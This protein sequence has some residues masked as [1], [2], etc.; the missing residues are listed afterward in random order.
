MQKRLVGIVLCVLGV[1]ASVALLWRTLLAPASSAPLADAAPAASTPEAPKPQGV[2]GARA[3]EAERLSGDA[4]PNQK[5]GDDDEDDLPILVRVFDGVTEQPVPG[6]RLRYWDAMSWAARL[7]VPKDTPLA[8]SR[9]DEEWLLAMGRIAICDAAGEARLL[10][11]LWTDVVAEFEGAVGVGKVEDAGELRITIRPERGVTVRLLTVDRQPVE[12]VAVGLWALDAAGTPVCESSLRESSTDGAGMARFRHLQWPL[13][14]SPALREIAPCAVRPRLLGCAAVFQAFSPAV[15]PRD[16]LELLLPTCGRVVV[17]WPAA[18]DPSHSDVLIREIGACWDPFIVRP[19][20][21][22]ELVFDHVAIGT[23]FEVLFESSW[24][25]VDGPKGAGDV[26]VVQLAEATKVALTGILQDVE[27]RVL[28]ERDCDLHSLGS[29]SFRAGRVRTDAAGRFE[30]A[31]YPWCL[32]RSFHCVIHVRAQDGEPFLAVPPVQGVLTAGGNDLGVLR[33]AVAEPL[34]SGTVV[35]LAGRASLRPDLVVERYDATAEQWCWVEGLSITYSKA[36][37]AI[38][39]RVASHEALRLRCDGGDLV[40]GGPRSFSPG[41][42]DVVLEI[43]QA[44]LFETQAR[45]DA[46][47]VPRIEVELTPLDLSAVEFAAL[48]IEPGAS[49]PIAGFELKGDRAVYA[50][51]VPAGNYDLLFRVRGFPDVLARV[52]RVVVG[53]AR[54]DARLL[55]VDLRG[56]LAT[57]VVDVVDDNGELQRARVTALGATNL[58]PDC[59]QEIVSGETLLVPAGPRDLLVFWPD[60]PPVE[61]RA[62]SG[63]VRVQVSR[64]RSSEVVVSGLSALPAG[65]HYEIEAGDGKPRDWSTC[66]SY[67]SCIGDSQYLQDGRA[68]LQFGDGP[69]PLSLRISRDADRATQALPSLQPDRVVASDTPIELRAPAAAAILAALESLQV[70][71]LQR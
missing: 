30:F 1:A 22:R 2:D 14:D 61:V 48:G 8:K 43:R 29:S 57:L 16:P 7:E 70:M 19:D 13:G 26:V 62:A 44:V 46:A 18:A 4:T 55:E 59:R 21:D 9:D 6:A 17:R 27:G 3:D 38:H 52:D 24:M 40:V 47:V 69:A 67:R 60:F 65:F 51:M 15:P 25:Q 41:Q 34:V 64:W 45:Y 23:R 42:R 49:L 37:F 5:S 12:G 10:A 71:P 50:G 53:G 11:S 33:A 36:G 68:R 56:K 63:R 31:S 39:G 54:P 35:D 20:T 58:G 66:E 32:G 28:A